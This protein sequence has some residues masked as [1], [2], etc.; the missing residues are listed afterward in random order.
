VRAGQ[1]KLRQCA[2]L[3]DV[4]VRLRGAVRYGAA[5][6]AKSRWSDGKVNAAPP[7]QG[8]KHI[9]SPTPHASY[10]MPHVRVTCPA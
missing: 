7:R 5:D 4:D 9:Y 1:S 10:F 3:V 2:W 8:A 6:E